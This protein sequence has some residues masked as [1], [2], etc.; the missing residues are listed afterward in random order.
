MEESTDTL[1]EMN[2]LSLGQSSEKKAGE[3]EQCL[4]TKKEKLLSS[5]R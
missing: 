2:L 4:S 5:Q 1:V 3:T